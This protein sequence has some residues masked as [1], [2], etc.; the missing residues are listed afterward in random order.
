MLPEGISFDELKFPKDK[1]AGRVKRAF[2]EM[3]SGYLED[4]VE[5]LK[6]CI[7]PNNFEDLKMILVKDIPFYS[8]CEHHFLPFFG[9]ISVGYWPD[10]KLV[11]LSKI[12]RAVNACCKRF[13]LQELLT[14]QI[15]T[16]LKI[17]L[18]PKGVAVM[19]KAEKHLCMCMRGVKKDASTITT[20]YFGVGQI[21]Q[22]E[23]LSQC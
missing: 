14:S 20:S 21:Y 17:A 7:I 23:F 15:A 18:Q 5:I 16:D 11:G 3:L 2:N 9:K 8:V 4:P 10:K 6:Q 19:V 1:T 22:K 13:Q 12:P